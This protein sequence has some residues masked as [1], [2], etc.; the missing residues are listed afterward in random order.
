MPVDFVSD[1][2][3]VG[4]FGPP[5]SAAS[6]GSGEANDRGLVSEVTPHYGGIT[7]GLHRADH[8]VVAHDS[9]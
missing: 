9:T 1:T 3:S 5:G 6:T 8:S 7:V 2:P 4:R